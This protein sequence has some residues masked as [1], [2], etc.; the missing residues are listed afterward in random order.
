MLL[1]AV[2]RRSVYVRH[3]VRAR[4]DHPELARQPYHDAL[5]ARADLRDWGLDVQPADSPRL[6]PAKVHLTQVRAPEGDEFT[7]VS[8]GSAPGK[9]AGYGAVLVDRAGPFAEVCSGFMADAPNAWAAEWLGKALGLLTLLSLAASRPKVVLCVADC[10]SA[11]M[12]NRRASPS[13]SPAVDRVR[14]WFAETAAARAPVV[15][16]AYI[17]AQ[18]TSRS[19]SWAASA[20]QRAHELAAEGRR[21]AESWTVPV[22]D[23][24]GDLWLLMKQGSICLSPSASLDAAYAETNVVGGHLEVVTGADPRTGPAWESLVERGQLSNGQLRLLAWMR[25]AKWLHRG[26]PNS[27]ICPFCMSPVGGWGEHLLSSCP[28]LA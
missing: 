17:P 5:R 2:N 9:A 22:P 12:S 27:L 28:R 23:L 25:A 8:D 15:R 10:S 6:S 24:L 26:D 11:V 20:Q 3:A 18:H 13:G 7:V 14:R 16:E 19:K 4:W 21:L 1:R